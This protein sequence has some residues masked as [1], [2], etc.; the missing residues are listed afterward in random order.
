[1][2][3]IANPILARF[4]REKRKANMLTRRKLAELAGID[5][6]YVTLIERDGFEPREDKVASLGRVLGCEDDALLT[7][8]RV[9]VSK[10]GIVR[11]ALRGSVA[12]QS[13]PSDSIDFVRAFCAATVEQR[14]QIMAVAAALLGPKKDRQLRLVHTT[15]KKGS[16]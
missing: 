14:E 2:S 6:S 7:C 8:R 3:R 4:V 1:M 5:P 12:L 13:V 11:D 10:M 16:L 9:P 15:Q